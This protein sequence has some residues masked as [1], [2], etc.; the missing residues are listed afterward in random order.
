MTAPVVWVYFVV[1][2]ENCDQV[3]RTVKHLQMDAQ[4]QLQNNLFFLRTTILENKTKCTLFLKYKI[5]SSVHN[6]LY[7]LQ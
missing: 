6:A 4:L 3:P 7:N 2:E 1:R 5:L